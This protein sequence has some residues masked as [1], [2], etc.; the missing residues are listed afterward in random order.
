M[1]LF[2]FYV[3]SRAQDDLNDLNNYLGRFPAPVIRSN[4]LGNLPADLRIDSWPG[5]PLFSL[6][7]AARTGFRMTERVS[8]S[9]CRCRPSNI[10]NPYQQR[11]PNFLSLDARICKP[12]RGREIHAAVLCE[13]I[14]SDQSL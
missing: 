14:Q 5:S 6:E 3:Q 9:C 2:V 10:G 12:A 11:F 7:S 4:E 1:A 8:V 13:H